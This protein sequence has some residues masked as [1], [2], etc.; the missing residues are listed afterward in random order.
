[1][2]NK[3]E[4]VNAL[5]YDNLERQIWGD[6]ATRG[7]FFTDDQY[8]VAVEYRRAFMEGRIIRCRGRVRYRVFLKKVLHKREEKMQ[9][10]M[11]MTQQ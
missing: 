9:E 7:F 10:K 8:R 2:L 11:K 3:L 4:T 1:M 6:V 5:L